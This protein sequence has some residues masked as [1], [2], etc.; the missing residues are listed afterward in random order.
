MKRKPEGMLIGGTLFL[1]KDAIL[2]HLKQFGKDMKA[3]YVNKRREYLQE[4]RP[5]SA[6][7]AH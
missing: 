5:Q 4:L 7:P 6:V 3:D 2:K 1:N